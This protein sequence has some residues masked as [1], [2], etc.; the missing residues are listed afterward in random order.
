MAFSDFLNTDLASQ[1]KILSAEIDKVYQRANLAGKSEVVDRL[2]RQSSALAEKV[3]LAQNSRV[4]AQTVRLLEECLRL[5]HECVPLMD[6]CLRKLLLSPDLHRHWTQKFSDTAR[7]L[8]EWKNA[9]EEK[10]S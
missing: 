3:A 4:A 2:R 5:T 10:T 7:R 1:A 9:A 6:L 8:E